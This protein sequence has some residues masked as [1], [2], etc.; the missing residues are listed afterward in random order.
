[1]Q[2]GT[3]L[4]GRDHAREIGFPDLP[5][6]VDTAFLQR[7][8]DAGGRVYAADRFNFVSLR[9]EDGR[10]HLGDLGRR[11]PPRSSASCSTATRPDYAEA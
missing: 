7:V 5:R 2:G 9:R 8:R 1:M 3:I 6:G 10:A 4:T 11:D